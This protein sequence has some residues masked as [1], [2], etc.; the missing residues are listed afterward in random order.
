[1]IQREP[2]KR[3]DQVKVTFAVAGRNGNSRVS[4]VGDFNGW[5]AGVNVFKR[6]G[7]S[8]MASVML[9]AGRRYEFRYVDDDGNWFNDDA[10][11]GYAPNAFGG[12][13]SV[14]DLR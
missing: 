4:L 2:T 11:D 7:E 3:G 13:N 5:R 1:M 12:D 6:K 8:Q 14:V 10:A 9:S